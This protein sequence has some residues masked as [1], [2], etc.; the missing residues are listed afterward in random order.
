[1]QIKLFKSY[2]YTLTG[3]VYIRNPRKAEG[4]VEDKV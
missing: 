4:K 2:Q 3:T 1:M